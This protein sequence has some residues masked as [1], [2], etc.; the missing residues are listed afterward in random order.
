M[1]EPKTKATSAS[2]E[3][4]L[5]KVEP[6]QKR[7]DGFMLLELFKKV[8]G[9]KPVMWGPTMVGFGVY[10]YKSERSS[11]EG[12]WLRIGFSPRKSALTLYVLTGDQDAPL[13]KK[14]GKHKTGVGCLYIDKLADIDLNVLE[15]L[16][17]ASWE[18]MQKKYPNG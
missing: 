13:L 16:V 5:N 7:A 15:D 9:E 8:A 3:E 10:H 14:L 11:Q 4:F 12:D 17:K 6:E 18:Y 1:A 2:V